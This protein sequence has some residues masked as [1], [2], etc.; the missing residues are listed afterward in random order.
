M[1]ILKFVLLIFFVTISFIS[2]AQTNIYHS[3]VEVLEKYSL[4]NYSEKVYVHSDKTIYNNEDDIWFTLYLINGVTHKKSNKSMLAYVELLNEKNDIINQKKLFI[5]N[6]STAGN[7][8]LS[9]SIKPGN[10]KIRAYTNHMKNQSSSYFFEKKITIWSYNN[11]II[12]NQVKEVSTTIANKE[13]AS[14]PD[15]HFYPQGGYL[16]NSLMNKVVIKL[17][18][19]IYDTLQVKGNIVDQNNEIIT[20]FTSTKFGLGEFSIIPKKGK[21]YFAILTHNNNDFKY[22]L[23]AALNK[24]FV[25]NVVNSDKKIYISLNTNSKNGLLGSSL[26]IHKRGKLMY[27]QKIKEVV[28]KKTLQIPVNQLN[29]GIIHITLFNSDLHPVCERLVFV[30]KE[31][32][33]PK[34]SIEKEK[35]YY[36]IRKKVNL[37]INVK[38]NQD[39]VIPSK[40]SLSVK[41]INT[42]PKEKFAENIKS[43]LL[44]NS[45]LRGKIKNPSYFFNNKEKRKSKYLLDLIMLTNGWRK[46]TWQEVLANKLNNLQHKPEKGFMLQ[47]TVNS[48]RSSKNSLPKYTRLTFPAGGLFKQEPIT[49]TDSIG[50]YSYGPFVFFDSIPVIVEA[51]LNNFKS[52]RKEDKKV[53]ITP[54]LGKKESKIISKKNTKD[55]IQSKI[56]VKPYTE[57]QKKLQKLKNKFT[58]TENVLN[59]VVVKAKLKK[60]EDERNREMNKRTSYGNAF[61]RTDL[62]EIGKSFGDIFNLLATIG[63]LTIN[64]DQV[65]VNRQRD[66]EPLILYNE[67]PIEAIEL[68]GIPANEVSFVDVLVGPEIAIFSSS[69]PVISIYSKSS[70]GRFIEREPGITNYK[71][72]GFYTAKEFYA[73]DHINGIEEQT[74]PDVRTTLHWAPNIIV[75]KDKPVEISFFTSDIKSEYIIEIEGIS[76]TGKPIYKTSKFFVE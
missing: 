73:P 7:F 50:N 51:R 70:S 35:E 17:K 11:E 25:L 67:L 61:N 62:N 16:V 8:T 19:K 30:Y 28:H 76:V 2:N 23:P 13:T 56:L 63:G 46:F 48:I 66:A 43:W 18:N 14:K 55:N 74:K 26:L 22:K 1:N 31:D 45:D 34:I 75:M 4:K 36:G 68:S 47:G 38:N 32:N 64:G 27:N 53:I 33:T 20:S 71:A 21:K 3:P 15:L 57:Q 37:K 54:K 44:L 39:I 52:K 10:Y 9:K 72:A 60:E 49:K 42:L 24:G 29:N 69:V 65:R 40:L 5:N 12:N 58:Q 41:D 6:L 59:E